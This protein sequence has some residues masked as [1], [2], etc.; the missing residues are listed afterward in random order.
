MINT[1][2][3]RYLE[4]HDVLTFTNVGASMRPLIKQGRDIFTIRKKI[5][6]E[7]FKK[8]DVVLYRRGDK[9]IMHR[10]T[11]VLPAGYIII[12]D[13][14]I[15][16]EFDIT[17]EKIIGVMTGFVRKGK[18]VSLDNFWYVFYSRL[19]VLIYPVRVPF[20]KAKILAWKCWHKF[21]KRK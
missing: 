19:W 2:I 8:Y 10:I 17:D 21:F 13:N 20:M 12:G 14:C 5:D 18:E 16:R 11:K 3:E 1:T 9:L 6:G 7:R 15:K 4:E